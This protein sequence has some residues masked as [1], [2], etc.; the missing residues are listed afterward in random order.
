MTKTSPVNVE[1]VKE[2]QKE[3][4]QKSS[5]FGNFSMTKKPVG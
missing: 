2:I 3:L 5:S 1:E 4:P